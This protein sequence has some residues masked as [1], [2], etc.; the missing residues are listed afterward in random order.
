L[1]DRKGKIEMSDKESTKDVFEEWAGGSAGASMEWF[2]P[3]SHKWWLK[4][5]ELAE[6]S[7]VLDVG[8]GTGWASRIVAKMVPCGEIVGIDF[9]EGM[10]QKARQSISKD[11]AHNYG[12]LLFK[13]AD[14]E[15]IHYPDN[16]FDAVI[17]LESFSWFP[18]P[19][20]A[21]SEVKRVLKPGG[22]L[23]V[24]DVADSQLLR[25]VLKISSLF[26]P[27]LDKWNIYSESQFKEFLE[28]EF[29][30]VYQK[31]APWIYQLGIGARVLLTV[32]TKRGVNKDV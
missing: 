16:Y 6:D 3:L 1:G 5:L 7:K 17:C 14:V 31:K 21:L 32:G 8:C 4:D 13:I 18:N 26:T 28:A 23:Y 29:G 2:H 24:A 15:D 12:N 22:K 20:T 11:K 10:V 30:D 27:G 25:P 19:E 9:T